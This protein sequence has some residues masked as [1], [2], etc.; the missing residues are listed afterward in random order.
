[1]AAGNSMVFVEMWRRSSLGQCVLEIGRTILQGE[2]SIEWG[3][4]KS[5]NRNVVE[6][7]D[8]TNQRSYAIMLFNEGCSG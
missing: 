1:M 7:G 5:V 2:F 6:C 8:V 3:R 4:L